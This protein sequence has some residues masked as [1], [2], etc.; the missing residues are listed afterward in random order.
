[1]STIDEGDVPNWSI[2]GNDHCHDTGLPT[3]VIFAI[4]RSC[5]A[6]VNGVR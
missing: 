4:L 5:R 6:K 3:T 1:M 2:G